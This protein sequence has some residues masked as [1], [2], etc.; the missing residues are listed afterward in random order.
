MSPAAW[1]PARGS[2]SISR[3]FARVTRPPGHGE[4]ARGERRHVL[5][6]SAGPA[7][8]GNLIGIHKIFML[9]R[10][11]GWPFCRSRSS[12]GQADRRRSWPMRI[13]REMPGSAS[14]WQA[15]SPRS[16][17]TTESMQ[18]GTRRM[19]RTFEPWRCGSAWRRSAMAARLWRRRP[20]EAG[21]TPAADDRRRRLEHGLPDQQGGA[22]GVQ[23]QSIPP[24]TV[25]VD[26]HGTG[27]G[28]SRYLQGEVDIVDASR[29]AKP[30]EE[31]Q[32]QG[33]GH[34]VDAVR[35]RLRWDHAGR[36]PQERL[37][38]SRSPSSS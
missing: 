4:L 15:V 3:A 35:G 32:G 26:N 30:D 19:T 29:L 6:N 2:P 20:G 17:C 14:A 37:R 13:A 21:S 11:T 31:S 22:G 7:H 23:R 18:T 28:F 34:R 38:A 25:V 1:V 5:M 9:G 12:L 8:R 24:I 10:Y 33:A 36:E 16:A 27:G